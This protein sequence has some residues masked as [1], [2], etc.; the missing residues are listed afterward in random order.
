MRIWIRR[1]VIRRAIAIIAVLTVTST[2]A[3]TL[4]A[5]HLPEASGTFGAGKIAT[6]LEDDDRPEPAS[7]A[8]DDHRRV[9]VVA[10]Y[11]AEAGTGR[12]AS[13]AFDLDG[14]ADALAASG[15]IGGFA[16]AGLPALL[17]R[18]RVPM[19]ALMPA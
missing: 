18:R 16:V 12:P 11:P 10:W 13:Y 2:V 4:G 5:L 6:I 1:A 17:P 8:A 19:P 15:E 7:P 9:R 14:I 3:S